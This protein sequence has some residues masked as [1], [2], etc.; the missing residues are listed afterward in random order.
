MEPNFLAL[1]V[2]AEASLGI[3]GFSA[4]LIG[5][6]RATDGFSV[7][8]NFRIQLLIYSAFGAMFGAL[9]PFAIF[10][11]ADANGSWAMINWIVCLY[12]IAGLFVFPKRMLAIR[13]SGFKVL[14]PLRLFF[15]QTGILSTIFL[16]SG[17]MI[18]DVIDLKSN[19]Y[20]IC[21]L[22]FLIQSSVAFIRT[23]FYRVT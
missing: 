4:I 14:F 5:L 10:K 22:L 21:L 19:V 9:I 13:K 18:I 3:L 11:S 12:S 16:L 1:Q 2:I 6:S 23:M 8:D 20:V 15:F 17:S 7:P